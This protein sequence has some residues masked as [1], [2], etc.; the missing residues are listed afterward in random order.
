[1]IKAVCFDL[2]HTLVH[3]D[4]PLN[5]Q[6]LYAGALT[7]VLQE[8]GIEV[9]QGNIASGEAVLLKYNTRV[10]MREYEVE[11]DAVFGEILSVWGCFD[12]DKHHKNAE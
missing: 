6:E 8:V 5:W 12:A 11:A 4:N 10:N 9:N 3:Y 2:G 1:M 7:R